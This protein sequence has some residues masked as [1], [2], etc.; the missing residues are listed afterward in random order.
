MTDNIKKIEEYIAEHKPNDAESHVLAYCF[1][2][3]YYSA[4]QKQYAESAGFSDR[5]LRSYISDNREL[6]DGELERLQD[7]KDADSPPTDFTIMANRT[8]TDEMLDK[9][10]DSLFKDALT[11]NARSKQL[12]IDFTGLTSEQVLTLQKNKAK[13]L[14][15]WIRENLGSI[16]QFMDAKSLGLMIESSPY[17]HRGNKE[18]ANN[19]QAFVDAD[20]TDESFAKELMYWGM[21]HLSLL[22]NV[23]HPDIELLS[24]AVRLDR[25]EAGVPETFNKYEVKQYAKGESISDVKKTVTD[26]E[27]EQMLT[28]VFGADE[29]EEIMFKRSLAK[30]TVKAPKVD[31]VS[32][33]QR[34]SKHEDKLQVL[35]TTEEELRHMMQQ[36]LKKAN[37]K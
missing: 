11:G 25:I 15:Y 28:E 18:S 33:E 36:T 2:K 10:V 37:Q 3:V 7:I 20:F 27:M 24:T 23:A 16:S 29:A 26:T 13:S 6:Y 14:R 1:C 4:T 31:K 21:V 19:A 34:A 30:D 35:L 9:F 17:I 32:V 8:I 22:N 5:L 12:F